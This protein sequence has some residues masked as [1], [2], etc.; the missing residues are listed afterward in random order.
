MLY[1]EKE[2]FLGFATRGLTKPENPGFRVWYFPFLL[3]NFIITHV[4]L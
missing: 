1:E 2:N 3:C 4:S